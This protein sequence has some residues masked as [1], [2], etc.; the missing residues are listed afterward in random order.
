MHEL[1]LAGGVVRL[2]EDAAVREGFHRVSQLRLEAGA[3]SGVEVR[4]L[5]FALDASIP[6]TCLEGAEILIDEPPG[7][8]WCLRCCGMVE[9]TSR[10]DACPRC[11]GF[12]LQPT[13]G[14]ELRV[15]DLLVHDD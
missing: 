1:S 11:G 14:T 7:A 13:G 2:V 15:V 8:A 3:L 9:I 10:A 12:Q 4:A 6:G 5:R